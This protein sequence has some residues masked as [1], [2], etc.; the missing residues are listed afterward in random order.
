M[1]LILVTV[2]ANHNNL[3]R[4]NNQSSA[5]KGKM[6]DKNNEHTILIHKISLE[7]TT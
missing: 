4:T 3:K 5:A 7:C 1:V 6:E 2:L